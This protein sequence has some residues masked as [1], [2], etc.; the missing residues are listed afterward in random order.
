MRLNVNPL[1]L[2]A[3]GAACA[4]K[5]N[6]LQPKH[7]IICPGDPV[8]VAW[9]VTGSATIKVTPST[10]G[11]PDG[12]VKSVDH[13]TFT[14]I[15][16]K[17]TVVVHVTR[18]LGHDA[19]GETTIDVDTGELVNASVSDATAKCTDHTLVST[20]HLDPRSFALDVKVAKVGVDG[21]DR[22]TYAVEHVG[23]KA[24]VSPGQT[25]DLLAGL[26]I[27]GDWVIS[28]VLLP[29]ES[30]DPPRFPNNLPVRVYTTCGGQP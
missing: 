11:A 23:K 29:D 4:A 20:A 10:P 17:T 9:S 18:T 13:A 21:N 24:T 27:A 25:T 6:D 12:D 1:L 14:P 26:P 7:K 22:R 5:V 28:T 19:D 30:C 16:T 8:T 2:V 15:A 3:I